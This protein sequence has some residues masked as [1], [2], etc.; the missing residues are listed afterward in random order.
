[1]YII[2]RSLQIIGAAKPYRRAIQYRCS[3]TSAIAIAVS[4]LVFVYSQMHVWARTYRETELHFMYSDNIFSLCFSLWC[5]ICSWFDFLY[6]SLE[7]AVVA[8][9]RAYRHQHWWFWFFIKPRLL[10][11]SLHDCRS[12]DAYV[13][14]WVL[15]GMWTR[16]RLY[17]SEAIVC[18]CVCGDCEMMC[19]RYLQLCATTCFMLIATTMFDNM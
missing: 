5:N 7:T 3:C 16:E 18:M 11:F 1:M 14:A 15:V 12:V 17:V 2:G 6:F 9:V 8:R 13:C 4:V 19:A 10:L